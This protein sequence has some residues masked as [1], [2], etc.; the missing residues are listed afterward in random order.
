[1]NNTIKTAL[2]TLLLIG[3][4]SAA[5]NLEVT[6]VSCTP[7]EAAVNQVFSCTAQVQNSGDA[8]GNL[9]TA[10]LYQSGTWMELASYPK[11]VNTNIGVGQSSEVTFSSL[12]GTESGNNGYQKITL[13]SVTDTYVAD[14]NVRINIIDI[15]VTVDNSQSSAA[16]NEEFDVTAEATAGG[17]IDVTLTFAVDDGGCSIG[18]QDSQRTITGMT[19]GSKQ[20]RTW[21]VTQGESG[22]CEYTM[23]ASA[24][25]IGDVATKTDTTSSV[26][27][28]TDCPTPSSSSSSSGGGG[29]GG[30]GS[31]TYSLG[32]LT[33]EE[34]LEMSKNEKA[35]FNIGEEENHTLRLTTWAATEI[36]FTIESEPIE[37]KLTIGGS[38][39]FDLDGDNK[40]DVRITLTG[41]NILTKKAT[42][43]I[44]PLQ[45]FTE[46]TPSFSP[47][48]GNAIEEIDEEETLGDNI[49]DIVNKPAIKWTLI[50][51]GAGILIVIILSL[52]GVIKYQRHREDKD[53]KKVKVYKNSIFSKASSI[54]KA[55]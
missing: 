12:R 30:G 52:L 35:S 48:T 49:G 10:T 2:M 21:T 8:S 40:E 27:T 34:T 6:T 16:M 41:N 50:I 7:S 4:V 14:E 33:K 47:G 43:V 44:T 45:D 32:L 54:I 26:V 29:G 15:V 11:T 24:T 5:A 22:N 55:K 36:T 37:F 17:N 38:K 42:V 9:G 51:I 1:M 25:G 3:M 20:S 23:S 13:D 46:D 53:N 18:N 31:P 28:C 39:T 19:D